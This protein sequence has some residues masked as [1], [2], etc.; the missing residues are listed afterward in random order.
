MKGDE[1]ERQVWCGPCGVKMKVSKD[2][3]DILKGGMRKT[4]ECPM[5]KKWEWE[6]NGDN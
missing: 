2:R 6:P 3:K 5:C 1:Y 4:V